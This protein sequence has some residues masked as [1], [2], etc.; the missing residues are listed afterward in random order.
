[1]YMYI[2]IYINTHRNGYIYS[3]ICISEYTYMYDF[4]GHFPPYPN[5]N[6]NMIHFLCIHVYMNIYICL[7][8][9]THIDMDI[10]IRTVFI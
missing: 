6:L 10:L 2:H 4:I 3:H 5:A 7:N 9:N 8:I 1:M